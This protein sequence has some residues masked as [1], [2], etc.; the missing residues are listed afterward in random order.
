MFDV[1]LVDLAENLL[2]PVLEPPARIVGLEVA[3]IA[4]PPAMVAH[5]RL[6][7]QLPV[8]LTAGDLLAE[9]DR[10]EHRAVALASTADVV[11]G[12][13]A[14]SPAELVERVHQIGAV[15]VV[16]HLLSAVAEDG[17]RLAG[18]GAAHQVG[19]EPVQLRARVVRAGETAAAE[20]DGRQVEV[21]PV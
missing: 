1:P 12:R 15:D 11:D 14:R 9:L 4:D 6:V 17:V 19:E 3:E 16:P 21:A 8:Q 7:A 20:A 2:D 13:G 10:L 18:H 5:P